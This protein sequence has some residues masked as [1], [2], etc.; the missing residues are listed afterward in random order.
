MEDLSQIPIMETGATLTE[1]DP[2]TS[3]ASVTVITHEQIVRAN[4]KN[5]DQ[6]LEIYVPGLTY[7][8]SVHGD[9][10]GIRGI[11][12]DRNNKILLLVNGR[13]MNIKA[14]DGGAAT[15]R[16]FS[17]LGD[18][19]RIMVYSDPGSAVFGPGAIAGVI[20]IET[21]SGSNYEGTDFHMEAGAVDELLSAEVRHGQ[22]LEN[23]FSLFL[24]AGIDK[25]HG[26]ETDHAHHKLAF[27]LTNRPWDTDKILIHA[28]KNMPIE[29]TRIGQ[30]FHD[31]PREK[32]HMQLDGEN[33]TLWGRWTQ[34]GIAMPSGQH[35]YAVFDPKD[36]RDT[37]AKNRQATLYGQYHSTLSDKVDITSS[38]SYMQTDVDINTAQQP[39]RGKKWVEKNTYLATLAQITP[40]S[41]HLFAVGCSYSYNDFKHFNQPFLE[42]MERKWYSDMLSFYGEYQWIVNDRWTAFFG[43]RADKHRF[44]QW[45]FSPRISVVYLPTS[46]DTIKLIYNHSN[47]H[48]DDYD[49]LLQH[50]LLDQKGD[51]ETIDH[52][53]IIYDHR[54]DSSWKF[55]SSFYFNDQNLVAYNKNKKLQSHLGRLRIWGI[56]ASFHY[57]TDD[58]EFDLSHT[59]TKLGD[60]DLADTDLDTQFVSAMPY[61]YGHDLM[62]WDNHITKARLTWHLQKGLEW[63]NSLRILWGKPGAVDMADYN[64]DTHHYDPKSSDF[65][66][67]NDWDLLKLPLY[68]DSK[69]AFGLSAFL[70]I[71]IIYRP[72]R[73]WRYGLHIYNLLGLFDDDLNKRNYV[74]IPS[75]TIDEPAS[76]AIDVAYSF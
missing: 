57:K 21:F 2:R 34:S 70:D 58:Y 75:H 7:S 55:E 42:V 40:D 76:V 28:N 44:T 41:N 36:L 72:N 45:M 62:A 3:P 24:Y 27:D 4:P 53:E 32:L 64:M 47:R 17:L 67:E 59:F 73:H 51:L 23:G 16:W 14:A 69:R 65:W 8:H 38:I 29:T 48:S 22:K 10:L 39:T 6:L 74:N 11:I 71:G 68:K 18:I 54:L 56:E 43:A 61:G 35:R 60:F 20:N 5:L 12:S 46:Y 25:A 9:Q 26:S 50:D 37:G 1:T 52:Y 63:F 19:R 49:L 30:S 13:Q 31:Q 33:F 66:K 15:E